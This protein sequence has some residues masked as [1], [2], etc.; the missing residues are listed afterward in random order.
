MTPGKY[1]E[2]IGYLAAN[3][4][5]ASDGRVRISAHCHNDLGLASANT[6]AAIESG[7]SQA[8]VT[9]LGIGERAGNAPLEEIAA[10]LF[11]LDDYS[12]IY[13]TR[14]NP[15]ELIGTCQMFSSCAGLP[16]PPGKAVVGSN[17][18]AHSS[19][20]H[21]NG[22]LKNPQTYQWMSPESF[23]RFETEIPLDRNSGSSGL[24]YRLEKASGIKAPEA[25]KEKIRKALQ[26]LDGN[27]GTMTDTELIRLAGI[28]NKKDRLL[29]ELKNIRIEQIDKGNFQAALNILENAS[30][31][32]F[33]IFSGN[34]PLEALIGALKLILPRGLTLNHYSC[35]CAGSTGTCFFQAEVSLVIKGLIL[36][37]RGTGGNDYLKAIAEAFI[38]A[39]NR[40]N[41]L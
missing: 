34:S 16:I 23:G 37:G 5:E 29:L 35:G 27:P 4:P 10:A 17:A 21:Q 8:E 1:G 9:L 28:R 14:L 15:E 2:L 39:V 18:F 11:S 33:P 38:A 30:R 3:I 25:L 36:T 41:V 40:F 24:A 12:S 20:I 7:A 13:S 6:L 22:F 26:S 19:G 31:D 32:L